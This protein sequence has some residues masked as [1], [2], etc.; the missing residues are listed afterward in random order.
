[1]VCVLPKI[2]WHVIMMNSIIIGNFFPFFDT[3]FCNEYHLSALKINLNQSVCI[4]ILFSRFFFKMTIFKNFVK[5]IFLDFSFVKK[6]QPH[7]N[8]VRPNTNFV[9][10]RKS[11]GNSQNTDTK[12]PNISFSEEL[13]E[14]SVIDG[15]KCV[16]TSKCKCRH[17]WKRVKFCH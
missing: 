10:M 15:N 8:T 3:S 1:M 7:N 4:I 9:H 11:H 6:N 5:N 13:I 16:T 2:Q 14:I 17:C 12:P